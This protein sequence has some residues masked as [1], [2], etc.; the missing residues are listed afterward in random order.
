MPGS[1]N[2][3]ITQH[4][5]YAITGKANQDESFGVKKHSH[6]N[7]RSHNDGAHRK[8]GR[9]RDAARAIP[10]GNGYHPLPDHGPVE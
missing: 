2:G 8:E 1:Y 4:H 5:E 9:M 3:P 6:S 7:G 10:K